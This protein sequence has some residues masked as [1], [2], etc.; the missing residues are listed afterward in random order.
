[1]HWEWFK[2]AWWKLGLSGIAEFK[3]FRMIKVERVKTALWS[4]DSGNTCSLYTSTVLTAVA[5]QY[6]AAQIT[7]LIILKS[8]L[9][10]LGRKVRLIGISHLITR[11]LTRRNLALTTPWDYIYAHTLNLLKPLVSMSSKGQ[12]NSFSLLSQNEKDAHT[13]S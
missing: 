2:Q 6:Q 10:T 11:R 7:E 9:M 3:H 4:L 13:S 5:R 8:T 12:G 1:M